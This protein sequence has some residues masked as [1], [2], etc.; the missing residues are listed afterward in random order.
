M[1]NTC[2]LLKEKGYKYAVMLKEN[3]TEVWATKAKKL[4][5]GDFSDKSRW[6]CYSRPLFSLYYYER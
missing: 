5:S 1:E 6:D 4:K 2:K 3:L